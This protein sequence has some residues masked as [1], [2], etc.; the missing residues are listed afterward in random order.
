MKTVVKG[1]YLVDVIN[2]NIIEDVHIIIEDGKIVDIKENSQNKY[3]DEETIIIDCGDNTLMPGLVDAHLHASL[4]SKREEPISLQHSQ[5]PVVKVLRGYNSLKQDLYAGVTTVRLLGDG[6]GMIDKYL[7]DAVK[8]GLIEGPRILA[9][10]QAIRPSHGTAAGIGVIADGID[11]VRK[12]VRETIFLGADVIKLFISNVSQGDS[13]LDYLKG[14]LTGIAAY[15]KEEIKVAVDTAHSVGLKVS[16]HCIGGPAIR[17]ALEAGVDSLEHVNLLEEEDIKYFLDTNSYICDPNLILFF[18]DE[19]GF[20]SQGNKSHKWDELPEWWH[21]KVY[22]AREKTQ[23]VM[24]KALAEGVKF[25]LAT[26]LNH[27]LLWKEA[28]YFIEK[29]GATNAQALKAITINGAELCGLE[30]EIGSVNIGKYADI[31]SVQG[32]PLTD[33]SA[34]KN[35]SLVMKEGR[36]IKK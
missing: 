11:E 6:D 3:D 26:D 17:W 23:N 10:I 29:L 33:I 24:K 5:P 4:N 7:R 36:V 2:G 25:A 30:N 12:K 20:E 32:N 21:E 19:I 22:I 9:A 1:K 31:I 16:A 27:G 18:D 34:L 8:E 14:D 13:F 35:V 15:T 28:K